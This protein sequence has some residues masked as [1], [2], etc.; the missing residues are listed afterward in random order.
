MPLNNIEIIFNLYRR[1]RIV[2]FLFALCL[3]LGSRAEETLRLASGEWKPYVSLAM[4]NYGSF[5]HIVTQAFALEGVEVEYGFFPWS[6]SMAI[7][8]RGDWDGTLP[9]GYQEERIKNFHHSEAVVEQRYFFFHLKS[10]KFD[11]QSYRNLNGLIIGASLGYNYKGGF[12]S[13]EKKGDIE[14]F[15]VGT[16]SQLIKMLL[17]GRIQLALIEK[18][19]AQDLMCRSFSRQEI[20]RITYHPKLQSR[21]GLH[22]L[23]SKKV[24]KNKH[25][26]KKFNR[27]LR[28]LKASG[29]AG[30]KHSKCSQ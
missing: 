5:S 3:S 23:L 8:E 20:A 15:R 21:D 25:L 28:R 7:A 24:D 2:F 1:A 17:A 10:F 13:A 12:Q 22:L 19:I 27:G 6:R 16:E 14:V 4:S 11:W 29:K 18:T 9:W 30:L 26:I